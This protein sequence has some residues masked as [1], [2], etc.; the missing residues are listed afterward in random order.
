MGPRLFRLLGAGGR[1]ENWGE[2]RA[3]RVP[4]IR[5]GRKGK[6]VMQGGKKSAEWLASGGG[7][8]GVL[9]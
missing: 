5:G 4:V 1:Q 9:E 6:K 8:K 3:L 7:L 2:K